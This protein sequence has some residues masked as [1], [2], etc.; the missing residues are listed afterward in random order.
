MIQKVKDFKDL[1]SLL[2]KQKE[3]QKS[4]SKSNPNKDKVRIKTKPN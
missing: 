1:K 3:D 2:A 4:N